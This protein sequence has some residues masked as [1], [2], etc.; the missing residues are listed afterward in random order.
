M[1]RTSEVKKELSQAFLYRHRLPSSCKTRLKSIEFWESIIKNESYEPKKRVTY[2]KNKLAF[3]TPEK[4][5]YLEWM[6]LKVKTK[7]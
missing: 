5:E 2:C 1:Q 4:I 6:A 7:K 3:Y